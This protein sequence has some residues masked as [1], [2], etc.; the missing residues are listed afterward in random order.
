MARLSNTQTLPFVGTGVTY[1]DASDSAGALYEA[2]KADNPNKEFL[3]YS[4][5][6]FVE[7]IDSVPTKHFVIWASTSKNDLPD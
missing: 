1:L 4:T 3:G 2:F 5:T 7:D 6:T